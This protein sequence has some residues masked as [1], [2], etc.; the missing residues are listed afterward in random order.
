MA[1]LLRWMPGLSAPG[2]R[3]TAGVDSGM[4]WKV[5]VWMA[6]EHRWPQPI[7]IS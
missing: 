6:C 4:E 7:V 3:I 5:Q 2:L 1:L